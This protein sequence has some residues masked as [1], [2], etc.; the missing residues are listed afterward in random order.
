MQDAI[1]AGYVVVILAALTLIG[2]AYVVITGNIVNNITG[3]SNALIA[4]LTTNVGSVLTIFAQTQT[5]LVLGV[6]L[7]LALFYL[8]SGF[9]SRGR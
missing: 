9:G 2:G 3:G 1:N 4:T 8:A 7:G 6:M 5:L